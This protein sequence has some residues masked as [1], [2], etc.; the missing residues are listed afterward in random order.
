MLSC[1]G[2][3]EPR[4]SRLGPSKS[5][6]N[7][8]NFIRSF[9]TSISIDFGTIRSW[10]VFCSWKL[11]KKPYKHLFWHSR[12]SKVIEF[13][14]N[15]EPV[16]DFVLVINSNLSPISHRYRDTAIYWLKITNFS[17]TLSFSI[18]VRSDSLWMYRK[19]LRFLKLV[20]PAADSEDLVILACTVFDW[21]T[22]VTNGQQTDGPTERQTKLRWQRCV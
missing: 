9:S 13:G 15:R 3:L 14:G 19:S 21:S 11:P 2:F 16:Y 6:F 20:F 7:A 18:L 1:A 22:R 10:N 12:S 17:Y 4:K 5:T 8:E